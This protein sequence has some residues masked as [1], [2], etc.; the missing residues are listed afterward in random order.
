M[1]RPIESAS[2]K[3]QRRPEVPKC[4]RLQ[5]E[6]LVCGRGREGAGAVAASHVQRKQTD[7]T[8]HGAVQARRPCALCVCVRVRVCVRV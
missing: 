4:R 7:K 1:T 8:S 5:L 3:G 2:H 6:A